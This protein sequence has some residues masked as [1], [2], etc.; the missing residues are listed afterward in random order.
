M[1]SLES[2]CGHCYCLFIV[3]IALLP[4]FV[5]FVGVTIAP[6]RREEGSL[7]ALCSIFELEQQRLFAIL[8]HYRDNNFEIGI[9]SGAI[10]MAWAALLLGFLWVSV[11]EVA[12]L[13]GD[14]PVL[15][16]M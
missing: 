6:L 4:P 8:L 7:T 12:E 5:R 13:F 1:R 10:L 9:D 16:M 14:N 2:G 3:L 11:I 15:L